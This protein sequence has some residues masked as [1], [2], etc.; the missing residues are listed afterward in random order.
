[1]DLYAAIQ[2]VRDRGVDEDAADDLTVTR[3]LAR[4]RMTID[5]YCGRDFLRR[6]ETYH[7]DGSGSDALFLEDRPVIKVTKLAVD[8]IKV[9]PE[10][11][12]LYEAAGYIRMVGDRTI[13]MGYP[14][15]FP[16]GVQNVDVTGIFGFDVFPDEV[17][18]ASVLLALMF[19]RLMRGEANVTESQAN[20]T[21]KAIGIRRVKVDDLS[22]DFEYPR[23][24]VVDASRTKTTG[25]A[26]ADRLL[27]R[28]RRDLE[29]I[30]V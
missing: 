19:L 15:T 2:D 9:E 22:V 14:G 1:V 25:L 4:A 23:E 13:F 17:V 18:E 16:V 27:W 7:V 30:V 26:E 20:T 10:S 6:R 8:G 11:Y 3:A 28:H 5:A 24:T 21:D 12:C 29:A